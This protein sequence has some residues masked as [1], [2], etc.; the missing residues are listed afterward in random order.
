MTQKA[1]V[2]K[3][4]KAWK[5]FLTTPYATT[6]S[7]V[8]VEWPDEKMGG[9]GQQTVVEIDKR[10]FYPNCYPVPW[11]RDYWSPRLNSAMEKK[12]SKVE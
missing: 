2:T 8:G 9:P 5:Q 10:K 1:I 11:I 7:L 12:Q 3:E 6:R 4:T